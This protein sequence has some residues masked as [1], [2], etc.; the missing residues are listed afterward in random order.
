V[1][2]FTARHGHGRTGTGAGKGHGMAGREAVERA[3]NVQRHTTRYRPPR[4]LDVASLRRLR[5]FHCQADQHF[6]G[7]I[8]SAEDENSAH[9]CIQ[10]LREHCPQTRLTPWSFGSGAVWLVVAKQ[11]GMRLL[12]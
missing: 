1:R 7:R 2:L 11:P 10:D 9:F 5:S 8:S 4:R 6:G 12:L 3:F